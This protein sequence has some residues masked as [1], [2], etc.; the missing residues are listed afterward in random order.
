MVEVFRPKK[1]DALAYYDGKSNQPPHRAARAVINRGGDREP[2]VRN[3][4]VSPLPISGRTTIKPLLDIY[5]R[6]I[7]PH[8]ARGISESK[9]WAFNAPTLTT[10]GN[11]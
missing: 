1:A 9:L 8:N 6:P 10:S 4:L 3:F 5:H 11:D 2:T 7:V